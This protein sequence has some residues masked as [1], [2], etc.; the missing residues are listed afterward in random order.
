MFYSF[1]KR[2]FIKQWVHV[3]RVPTFVYLCS[4]LTCLSLEAIETSRIWFFMNMC[5][6]RAWINDPLW[7]S[8]SGWC[9]MKVTQPS[10][11]WSQILPQ[12]KDK[13][14]VCW[15]KITVRSKH[16][17]SVHS[18]TCGTWMAS[19]EYIKAIVVSCVKLLLLDIYIL[20]CDIWKGL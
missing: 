1:G 17:T 11:H 6:W 9:L 7:R 4:S 13:A 18:T 14:M 15:Y 2:N 19:S 12:S 16:L 3:Y 10:A 5:R 20:L 8:N